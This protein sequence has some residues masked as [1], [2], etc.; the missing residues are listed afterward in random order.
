MDNGNKVLS[1]RLFYKTVSV[2][3]YCCEILYLLNDMKRSEI[4]INWTR[5]M[6]SE[7]EWHWQ[8]LLSSCQHSSKDMC[9]VGHFSLLHYSRHRTKHRSRHFNH[10]N[11]TNSFPAISTSS[12]LNFYQNSIHMKSIKTTH[13]HTHTT[14]IFCCCIVVSM[15]TVNVCLIT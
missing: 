8:E 2:A 10:A 3:C 15:V 7:Y 4:N 9:K 12:I 5:N 1:I 6:R 14:H 11:Y 13:A